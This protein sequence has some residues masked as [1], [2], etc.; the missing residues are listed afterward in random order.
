MPYADSDFFL[1]L[2]KESDWL[3]QKAEKILKQ[4][5]GQIWTSHWSLVEI[6]L[7]SDE[8]FLDPEIIINSIRQI[9]EIKGDADIILAAAHLMKKRGMRTFD[10]LHAV[11][12]NSDKIIS[13]DSIF[14]TFLER[15]RLEK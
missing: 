6:L 11:S 14:D 15:I 5:K 2:L 12:C 10:A 7:V 3:S 4:Y 13:S 9:A 8:Y 1:A